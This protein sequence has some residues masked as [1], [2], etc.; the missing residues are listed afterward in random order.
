[1][2][3]G[4]L[5]NIIKG[6]WKNKNVNI[7]HEVTVVVPRVEL[8]KKIKDNEEEIEIIMNSITVVHPPHHELAGLPS[9]PVIPKQYSHKCN[10]N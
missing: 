6:I 9:S 7:P 4:K 1:M 8:R 5:A 3:F 2:C 10:K